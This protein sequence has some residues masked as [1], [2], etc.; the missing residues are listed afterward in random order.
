[1]LPSVGSGVRQKPAAAVLLQGACSVPM[2]STGTLV[3]CKAALKAP[4]VP[5]CNTLNRELYNATTKCAPLCSLISYLQP[6]RNR[7]LLE[8]LQRKRMTAI[9]MDMIPRTISRAQSF[10]SL[11]SQANIAGYRAVIEAGPC[12]RSQLPDKA[13]IPTGFAA[14]FGHGRCPCWKV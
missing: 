9:G 8:A 2:L 3:D 6:A 14:A 1:M 10:D 12:S 5:R 7:E 4:S 13:M 11:S